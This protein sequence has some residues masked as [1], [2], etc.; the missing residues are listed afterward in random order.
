MARVNFKKIK[1]WFKIA[2]ICLGIILA[3]VITVS[4]GSNVGAVKII[5]QMIKRK[6]GEIKKSKEEILQLERDIKTDKAN[7]EIDKETIRSKYNE[8]IKSVNDSTLQEDA[9]WYRKF[10]SE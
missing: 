1:R 10:I 9:E 3:V 7:N 5:K 8:K 4:V 2:G 6:D